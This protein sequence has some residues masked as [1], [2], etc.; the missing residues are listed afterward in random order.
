MRIKTD[1]RKRTIYTVLLPPCLVVLMLTGCTDGIS[2]VT[3]TGNQHTDTASAVVTGKSDEELYHDAVLD[4]MVAEEDEI[5]PVISLAPGE[6][7]ACYNADQTELLL[8]VYH[9]DPDDFPEG[10]KIKVGENGLWTFSGGEMA[11]WYAVEAPNMRNPAR[12]F[13]QVLGR[14][15]DDES[16]YFTAVWADRSDVI[17]PAYT[18]DITEMVMSASFEKNTDAAY[19]KW[20]DDMIISSYYDGSKSWTRLG[21]TYDWAENGNEYGLSE[22]Y[23]PE[24]SEVQAVYTCT[25]EEFQKKLKNGSW[26]PLLD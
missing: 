25:R 9:D 20:F 23:I 4:A 16:S 26:N 1:R 12:R 2:S 7:Y 19:K 17:R 8:F 22:F 13:R 18:T 6:P 5:L 11:D 21:Y 10:K 14:S 3:V 24:G 15:P